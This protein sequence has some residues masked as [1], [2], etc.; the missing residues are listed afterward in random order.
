MKKSLFAF[1]KFLLGL[2]VARGQPTMDL[3]VEHAETPLGPWRALTRLHVPQASAA[4]FRVA[5]VACALTSS[6]HSATIYVENGGKLGEAISN[7]TWGTTIVVAPGNYTANNLLKPGVDWYFA[8]GA[9]VYFREPNSG[10]G[11]GIFDDRPSGPTT[12]YIGGFGR[13]NYVVGIPGYTN[14]G[15]FSTDPTNFNVIGMVVVTNST[16]KVFINADVLEAGYV[17][18]FANFAVLNAIDGEVRVNA[19]D[20]KDTYA[21]TT[22]PIGADEEGTDQGNGTGT[23]TAV[24]WQN[25]EMYVNAQSVRAASRYA[26]WCEQVAGSRTTNNFY[27]NAQLIQNYGGLSTIYMVG[28]SNEYRTWVTANLVERLGGA[29]GYSAYAAYSGGRHYLTCQKASNFGGDAVIA[30]SS[31][32]SNVTAWVTAQKITAATNSNWIKIYNSGG[33]LYADIHHFEDA[34][35]MARGI[36]IQGGELH[37]RGGIGKV[38]AGDGIVLTNCNAHIDNLWLDTSTANQA[39][40][41]PLT[42]YGSA[43]AR[44]KNVDL[45]A[46]ALAWGIQATQAHSIKI[47]G[48]GGARVNKASAAAGG[49]TN[50]TAQ[51]G[52]IVYD[53]N[54]Q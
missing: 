27:L 36:W 33:T 21:G 38:L 4:F 42:L 30:L 16:S 49:S 47:L 46:P 37:L 45:L 20:I 40:N 43:T 13:F 2:L 52:T 34:G 9:V 50:I 44:L 31:P 10:P 19:R 12:N 17:G 35:A 22:V 15:T 18:G 25:G 51:V 48:T 41:R 6:V 1:G 28:Y 53:T 3:T 24:L 8:E 7:A 14:T 26:I 29:A 32:S 5:L 11:W 39:T 23:V 54:L